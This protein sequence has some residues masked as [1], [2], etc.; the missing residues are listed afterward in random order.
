MIEWQPIETAPKDGRERLAEI[1]I[2][3]SIPTGHGDTI[4]DLLTELDSWLADKLGTNGLFGAVAIPGAA[5]RMLTIWN[6]VCGDM[7][8]ARGLG[9]RRR[10]KL[11]DRFKDTF[12]ANLSQWRAYCERVRRS[13]FLSGATQQFRADLSW[14]LEPQ[15]ITKTLEGRYDDRGFQ[16]R[17]DRSD[18]AQREA[19]LVEN[20]RESL[21]RAGMA[22]DM[23]GGHSSAGSKGRG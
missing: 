3:H 10:K 1:M 5:E 19:E 23:D 13:P 21:V 8:P 2:R 4:D 12:H 22:R 14:V 17:R 6:E 9:D 15:N 16:N 20:S 11:L 7:A 18:R